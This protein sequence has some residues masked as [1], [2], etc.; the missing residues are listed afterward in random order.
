MEQL[1]A[2]DTDGAER[3]AMIGVAEPQEPLLRDLS[4]KLPVLER[5]LE[6]DRDRRRARVRIEHAREPRRCDLDERRAEPDAW[7][8]REPEKCRVG[9]ALELFA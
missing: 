7:L 1:D 9:D 5:L 2:T 3:V 6:R 8:V 4:S